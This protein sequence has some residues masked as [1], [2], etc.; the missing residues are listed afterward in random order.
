MFWELLATI[1]AGVAGA[2]VMLLV[3]R[4]LP[5]PRWL[6][7]V[8]AGAAML[9]AAISS[10]YGWYGRT[11]ASLPDGVTVA[12]AYPAK[13]FWR[14]WTYLHPMTDRFVAIDTR[15]MQPND[16]AP[17]LYLTDM[18]MF[19]R[20]QPTVAAQILVDCASGRRAAPARGEGTEPVWYAAGHD[21]AIVQT[22]CEAS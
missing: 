8:G 11:V 4:W 3:T 22:V 1:F 17:A 21:D 10:E 9:A 5:L 12:E 18:Y 16:G 2:G 6:V 7:P 15:R 14:P 13:A 19:V 20:W